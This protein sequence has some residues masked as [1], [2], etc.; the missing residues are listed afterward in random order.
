MAL[1]VQPEDSLRAMANVQAV[2]GR[3]EVMTVGDARVRL[4]LAKNPAGWAETLDLIRPAP[5][6]VVIGINARVADGRDPSWLWDVPFER[7]KGRLVVATGDRAKDLAVRLRYAEVDHACVPGYRSA[8][9]VASSA[10]R[11]L[12]TTPAVATEAAATTAAPAIASRCCNVFMSRLLRSRNGTDPRF[13]G[14]TPLSTVPVGFP[15]CPGARWSS[16]GPT[17][18]RVEWRP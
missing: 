13:S 1:G 7:L 2:A 11:W 8:V 5:V 14:A 3:Y 10:P 16:W 17:D 12:A 18:A 4:L 6:P 9:R 15:R